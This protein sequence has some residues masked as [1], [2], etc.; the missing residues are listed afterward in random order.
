MLWFV[1][2]GV[3]GTDTVSDKIKKVLGDAS[4]VYFESFTSP[5]RNIDLTKIR[6]LTK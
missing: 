6:K 2:I 1:G 5:S 4:V 3:S